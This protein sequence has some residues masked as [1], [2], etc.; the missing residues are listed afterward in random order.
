V[1]IELGFITNDGDC[2]FLLDGSNRD[3]VCKAIFDT[4]RASE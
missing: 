4:V 2:N 1:L 3:K